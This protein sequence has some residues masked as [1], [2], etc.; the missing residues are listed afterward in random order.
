MKA[1]DLWQVLICLLLTLFTCLRS[2]RV[3][4][5]HDLA[6]ERLAE[7]DIDSDYVRKVFRKAEPP[8]GLSHGDG[9]PQ[10]EPEAP[11][12]SRKF[13]LPPPQAAKPA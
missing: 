2:T 1:I 12:H 6:A 10:P 11:E 8:Q 13:H 3:H 5:A 7:A 9:T 4:P